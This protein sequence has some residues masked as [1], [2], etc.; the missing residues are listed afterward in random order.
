MELIWQACLTY[1]VESYRV[2]R[3][4]EEELG[5]PYLRIETDYSPSDSAAN[6]GPRGG[7]FE[8]IRSY[9]IKV[10]YSSPFVPPEWIAA[11]DLRPLWLL[12]ITHSTTAARRGVCRC[13]NML[14]ELVANRLTWRSCTDDDL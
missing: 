11:H 12:G 8:T 1:D 7:S 10:A 5:L 4:V 13:A 9:M 14:V 6:R 3:F 2:K